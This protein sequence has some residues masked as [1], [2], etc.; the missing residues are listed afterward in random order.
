MPI[1]LTSPKDAILGGIF[2]S[3]EVFLPT[4]CDAIEQHLSAAVLCCLI[5]ALL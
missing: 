5:G 3:T 4:T 1:I 2:T